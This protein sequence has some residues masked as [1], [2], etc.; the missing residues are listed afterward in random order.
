M[1]AEH[2]IHILIHRD[3]GLITRTDVPKYG[4]LKA[5]CGMDNRGWEALSFIKVVLRSPNQKLASN[6][7]KELSKFVFSSPVLAIL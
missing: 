1:W 4:F 3:G 6:K 5:A 7:N 2:F